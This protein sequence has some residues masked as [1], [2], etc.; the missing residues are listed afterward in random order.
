[1]YWEELAYQV[2]HHLEQTQPVGAA[3]LVLGLVG[4]GWA[5]W[6]AWRSRRGGAAA[7]AVATW[8]LLVQLVVLLAGAA[9]LEGGAGN[10]VAGVADDQ[11]AATWAQYMNRCR[12]ALPWL[13]AVA[14][15]P[16][17]AVL[18]FGVRVR[19]DGRPARAWSVLPLLLLMAIGWVGS[20]VY[21]FHFEQMVLPMLAA[22]VLVVRGAWV[23]A[24]V[25]HDDDA[26]G[27]VAVALAIG[28]T[29]LLLG[30]FGAAQE[31]GF[32]NSAIVNAEQ[33][34]AALLRRREE[35]QT[36]YRLI[37]AT[38]AVVTLP[39]VMLARRRV[40]ML[41]VVALIGMLIVEADPGVFER[42]VLALVPAWEG[43]ARAP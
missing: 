21:R 14:A 12:A 1:M 10:V 5:S 11:K 24:R 38:I 9:W 18:V 13:T 2:A 30:G 15:A 7:P 34:A 8:V 32:V 26:R 40:W 42:Q 28:V 25:S 23:L 29:V 16:G 39:M 33:K 37:A 27:T 6:V 22:A 17:A 43:G 3:Q 41:A 31:L 19:G 35:L 4:L 36:A 20:G